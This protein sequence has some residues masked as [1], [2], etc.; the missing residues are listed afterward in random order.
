MILK[1]DNVE[2]RS[3]QSAKHSL[4]YF[5]SLFHLDKHKKAHVYIKGRHSTWHHG[6]FGRQLPQTI[7]LGSAQL[8]Q[9]MFMVRLILKLKEIPDD[10]CWQ[11]QE[12]VKFIAYL[13]DAY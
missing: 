8:M 9:C 4:M 13:F 5:L 1:I 11:Q 6:R 7:P 10:S 12:Y 3:K 2:F